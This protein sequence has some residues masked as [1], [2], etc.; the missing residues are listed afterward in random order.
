N[1]LDSSN[2]NA[3]PLDGE[4]EAS[5]AFESNEVSTDSPN[6]RSSLLA[7]SIQKQRTVMIRNHKRNISRKSVQHEGNIN[8]TSSN[9]AIIRSE[10]ENLFAKKRTNWK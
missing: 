6:E 5:V 9:K 3:I 8:A 1:Y 10:L 2:D 4:L 7:P